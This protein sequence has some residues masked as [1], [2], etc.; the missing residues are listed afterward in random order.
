MTT[1]NREDHTCRICGGSDLG[2][3]A[4]FPALPRVTSDSK[5]WPAG[6]ALAVCGDCGAMQ[7]LVTPAWRE[8]IERIYGDYEIY[9][10][11][12]GAEQPI[13]QAGSEVAVP[14][15][16][17]IL[18][19][20]KSSLDLPERLA[21][22]DF[23]C[24][25]GSALRMFAERQPG[26]TLYGA[27]IS[28]RSL[29][30]LRQITSFA[31]L[32]T[33]PPEQILH[34]FDLVTAIHSIEHVIEPVA[35]LRALGGRLADGGHL[36]VQVP[37]CDATPYDLVIADHLTHFT[38][39][40]LALAI[41][42][43]GL[44]TRELSDRVLTKELT[45]VGRAAAAGDA[46]A[47]LRDAAK[48]RRLAEAGVAWLSA[49]IAAACDLAQVSPRIG[50]FGTS[51]SGTWLAGGLG[52]RIAFFVDEDTGR[53]GR[54]HMGKPIVAPADVPADADVLMPLIPAVAGPIIQRHKTSVSRWHAPPT[55]A[56][57]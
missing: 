6:G 36:A 45:W 13:Y 17:R 10:Q 2:E 21:A 27:E 24:G 4:G 37:D 3:I 42:R 39:N 31:E 46:P 32:F 35:T 7:K 55:L 15:S 34:R 25:T 40:S 9:H 57:A 29:T 11:S 19:H 47:A 14:R 49:Q 26:W 16:A 28:D 33:C 12:A 5:P 18:D 48:G 56:A 30:A 38:S 23:G 51:I 43:A 22:L 20:I 8:E 44:A 52:D 1:N 54:T 50:I 53:I 41:A